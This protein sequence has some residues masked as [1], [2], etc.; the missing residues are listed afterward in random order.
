MGAFEISNY[1]SFLY[2]VGAFSRVADLD[3]VQTAISHALSEHLAL[4]D[5]QCLSSSD[6]LRVL[7]T[8]DP[9][10]PR[11]DTNPAT[12]ALVPLALPAEQVAARYEAAYAAHRTAGPLTIY[13]RPASSNL[14]PRLAVALTGSH[15]LS[16]PSPEA[17]LWAWSNRTRLLDAPPSATSGSAVRFVAHPQ[18]LADLLGTYTEQ[19]GEW[20][21][22]DRLLR[23]LDSCSF[24]LG[25]DGQAAT[26]TAHAVPLATA[27]LH[28]L[29]DA[30]RIPGSTLW[31]DY[32]DNAFYVSLAASTNPALG[33][34]YLG[35][36]RFDLMRAPALLAPPGALTGHQLTYLAPARQAQGL[37]LIHVEPLAPDASPGVAA[38]LKRLHTLPRPSTFTLLP[39]GTFACGDTA[40][41]RYRV[42]TAADRA[43]QG[44]AA[45]EKDS[46]WANLL[47]TLLKRAVFEAAVHDG[48]YIAA[49]G[50]TNSI[51][52]AIA[53]LRL[54][55]KAITLHRRLSIQDN[56]LSAELSAASTLQ[57]A[58]LL[59]HLVSSMPG[60][61]EEKLRLLPSGGD[62][63]A[64]GVCRD[65]NRRITF[66]LRLNTTEIA[67][68]QRFNRS[69][70]DLL[71]E[72]F[73]RM[74]S[75]QML[76]LPTQEEEA[77]TIRRP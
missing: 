9:A 40:V 73:L 20:I 21:A 27:P 25:F 6:L 31:H 1:Q 28:T 17:L 43:P 18:R 58:A 36:V 53:D 11:G 29:A 37:C 48:H 41:Q 7:L 64:F 10:L 15:L 55:D 63:A 35:G 70:R 26:F 34:A 24:A 46:T 62:G 56:A 30:W 76:N 75:D 14:P 19:V 2:G 52:Q 16:S 5:P 45:A 68:L 67:T 13:E 74:F 23:D 22:I 32:P 4:P 65:A 12:V 38:A 57:V 59:R 33:Q 77:P 60:V 69:G 72:A 61:S 54:P 50:P 66:S 39:D 51:E 44:E 3:F 42:E 47:G 8:V 71:Q 49:L